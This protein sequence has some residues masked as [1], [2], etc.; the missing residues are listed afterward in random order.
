MK[1]FNFTRNAVKSANLALVGRNLFMFLPDTNEWTDPE[2]AN[3][4][5]NAQGVS[6]LDNT[7]PTRIIGLSLTVGL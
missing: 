7:P 1:W 4:T 3:T 6:G 2:F 5:G